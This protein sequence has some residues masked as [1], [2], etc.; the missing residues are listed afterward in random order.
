MKDSKAT[1]KKETVMAKKRQPPPNPWVRMKTLEDQ[2]AKLTDAVGH[3]TQILQH[4]KNNGSPAN[5]PIVNEGPSVA[6]QS[7]QMVLT[8]AELISR[9]V[10]P[11]QWS[12]YQAKLA[13]PQRLGPEIQRCEICGTPYQ[14]PKPPFGSPCLCADHRQP[15][16]KVT[17]CL[18][19]QRMSGEGE[20]CAAC[21]AC[22]MCGSRD[23][24]RVCARCIRDGVKT[25][26]LCTRLPQPNS[27]FCR[28]CDKSYKENNANDFQQPAMPPPDPRAVH[29]HQEAVQT[30]M[31]TGDTNLAQR[32][33][34]LPDLQPAL[35]R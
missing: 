32:L 25:C 1:G 4:A 30:A 9:G 24:D 17:A 20:R 27:A 23:I 10:P 26:D 15:G 7:R 19:G 8:P 21:L 11:D 18:C 34:A 3:I 31:T 35:P 16:V 29:E 6:Q 22:V 14:G 33:Q 13:Q 5:V 12:A 28:W 2:M